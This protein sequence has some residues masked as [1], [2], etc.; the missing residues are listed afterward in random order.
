MAFNEE[1]PL[2]KRSAKTNKVLRRLKIK[3][4]KYTRVQ[5]KT[6]IVILF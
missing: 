3:K 6:K 1:N 4:M 2:L 5:D